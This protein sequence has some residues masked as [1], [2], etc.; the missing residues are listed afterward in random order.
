MK[1]K[2][3]RWGCGIIRTGP[4]R[5][6]LRNSADTMTYL[7]PIRISTPG[8]LTFGPEFKV[9]WAWYIPTEIEIG[10]GLTALLVS[11]I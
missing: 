5:A 1:L 9:G 6:Q 10:P 4:G 11:G 8:P 2:N 3:Q 7:V